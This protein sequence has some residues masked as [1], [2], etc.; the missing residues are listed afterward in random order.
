MCLVTKSQLNL[1][2]EL[3]TEIGKKVFPTFEEV[4]DVKVFSECENING[5]M[6]HCLLLCGLHWR[7]LKGKWQEILANINITS[8]SG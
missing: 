2:Y 7:I 4:F 5:S 8:I 1:T 3:A 6:R